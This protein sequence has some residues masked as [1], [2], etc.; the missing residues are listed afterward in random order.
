MTPKHSEDERFNR[1]VVSLQKCLASENG[2]W[3]E[4]TFHT[5]EILTNCI[6]INIIGVFGIAGNIINIIVLTKHGFRETT[7]IILVALSLSDLLFSIILPVTRLKCI[8]RHF[9]HGLAMT[10]NTFVTVYLFMPKYVCLASSFTYVTMIAIERFV[11]VFFPFKVSMIFKTK[12][13]K[14]CVI[15]VPVF[16][17]VLL[18]PTLRALRYDWKFSSIFNE[19]VAVVEYTQFYIDNQVFLD[20]YAWVG[21]N[22]FFGILG[23]VVILLCCVAIGVKLFKA[24]VKRELM[25][26]R[27]T[28]YD[29]KV[30]KMLVT[31]CVIFLAVSIPNFVLYAYFVPNFIFASKLHELVDDI[32][33]VLYTVN[34]S[35]NFLVYVTM[36]AKFARTYRNMFYCKWFAFK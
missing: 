22:Y 8:T 3:S 11:A 4:D 25:T 13:M 7:N 29:V 16:V 26:S 12:I 30:V 18:T 36:S 28:G 14:I 33:A 1:T 6:I 20:F 32:C 24:S 2:P 15:G 23:A 35:A 34:S 10:I 21:L 5:L 9:N 19:T 27:S 31:V 17:L